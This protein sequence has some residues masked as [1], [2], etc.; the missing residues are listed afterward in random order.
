MASTM[1]NLPMVFKRLSRPL[2]LK[3]TFSTTLQIAIG[4]ATLAVQYFLVF[5]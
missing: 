3:I 4:L 5:R 2:Q 1:T